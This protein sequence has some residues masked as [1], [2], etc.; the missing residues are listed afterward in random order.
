MVLIAFFIF[1]VDGGPDENPRYQKEIRV[2]IHHFLQYNF[3]ALFIA[4]NALG[5]S[6]FNRVGR[7]MGPLS[8]EL[9]GLI[10]PHDQYGSHLNER[11][12]TI[13]D[14]LEKKNFKFAGVNL[15]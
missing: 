5:R 10:L 3:D 1:T 4:T 9:I 13:D 15:A 8:K 12:I 2:T 6:A 11:G 7:K 14:D